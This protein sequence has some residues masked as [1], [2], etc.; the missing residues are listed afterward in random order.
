[1]KIE[2]WKVPGKSAAPVRNLTF[3]SFNFQFAILRFSAETFC[4]RASLT[5]VFVLA[6]GFVTTEQIGRSYETI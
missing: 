4:P 1:M 2:N 3:S 5:S 6:I